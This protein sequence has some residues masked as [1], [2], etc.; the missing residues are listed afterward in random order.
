MGADVVLGEYRQLLDLG[1]VAQGQADAGQ[2]L[3]VEGRVF[4]CLQQQF[5]EPPQLP[6]TDALQWPVLR[7]AQKVQ[8][9][10][11][12]A[13]SQDIEGAEEDILVQIHACG[14]PWRTG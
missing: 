4:P 2:P 12:A 3:A 14:T 5:I 13:T 9:L 7:L 10:D 6:L 1:Q 8:A 11:V